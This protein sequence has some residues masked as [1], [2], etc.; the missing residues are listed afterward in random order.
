MKYLRIVLLGQKDWKKI[1][2]LFVFQAEDGIRDVAVTGVQTCALPILLTLE[3]NDFYWYA[4]ALDLLWPPI[5]QAL[6][7]H[8]SR[9]RRGAGRRPH[10][11]LSRPATEA[12][13]G[14]PAS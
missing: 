13:P 3:L 4:A 11:R 5:G 1:V 6:E 10:P 14:D 9:S 7:R 8:R 2:V 12:R